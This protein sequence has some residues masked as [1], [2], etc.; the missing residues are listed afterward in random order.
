MYENYCTHATYSIIYDQEKPINGGD[1]QITAKLIPIAAKFAF[2]CSPKPDDTN[3]HALE[4]WRRIP[5]ERP[6]QPLHCIVCRLWLERMSLIKHK[7]SQNHLIMDKAEWSEPCVPRCSPTPCGVFT[8][9]HQ[10][11]RDCSAL[12]M[13]TNLAIY[14][15]IHLNYEGKKTLPTLKLQRRA[16]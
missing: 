3:I 14:E 1:R 4:Q 5:G 7:V 8:L 15:A 12:F 9:P 13:Q 6:E 16:I 2:D 10:S 11:W